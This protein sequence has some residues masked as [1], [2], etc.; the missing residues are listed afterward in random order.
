MTYARTDIYFLKFFH[1][2]LYMCPKCPKLGNV[3]IINTL[4]FFISALYVP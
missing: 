1:F 4:R 3:L 2:R